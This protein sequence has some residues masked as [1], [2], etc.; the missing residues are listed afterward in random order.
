MAMSRRSM[1]GE[2]IEA[3]RDHSFGWPSQSVES[4][5]GV[6]QQTMLDSR[7]HDLLLPSSFPFLLPTDPYG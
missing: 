4:R 7:P 5:N 2:R 1:S 6:S 3:R